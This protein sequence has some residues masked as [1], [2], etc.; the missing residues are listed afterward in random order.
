MQVRCNVGILLFSQLTCHYLTCHLMLWTFLKKIQC[1]CRNMNK[2]KNTNEQNKKKK[3][4]VHVSRFMCCL[5]QCELKDWCVLFLWTCGFYVTVHQCHWSHSNN[6]VE[7]MMSLSMTV[8]C[9]G[10]ISRYVKGKY[11]HVSTNQHKTVLWTFL[12]FS[13]TVL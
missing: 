4:K 10:I 11:I 1:E 5:S 3:R 7:W 8:T 13:D 12:Q 6:C 9:I 2:C